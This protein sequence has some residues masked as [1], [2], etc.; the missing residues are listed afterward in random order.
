MLA[1]MLLPYWVYKNIAMNIYLY[2]LQDFRLLSK[3]FVGKTAGFI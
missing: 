2:G 3:N 1:D